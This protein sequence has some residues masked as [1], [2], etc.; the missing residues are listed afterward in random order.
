MEKLNIITLLGFIFV[1][2]HFFKNLYLGMLDYCSKFAKK[3]I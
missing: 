3:Y 2:Y 1:F